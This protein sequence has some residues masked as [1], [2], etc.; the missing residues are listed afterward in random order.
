[1]RGAG[2]CI[3]VITRWSCE[4]SFKL[5]LLYLRKRMLSAQW[6]E[7]RLRPSANLDVV[8]KKKFCLFWELNLFATRTDSNLIH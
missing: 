2:S 7:D 1:M 5:W 6:K 3:N 4:I 8:A